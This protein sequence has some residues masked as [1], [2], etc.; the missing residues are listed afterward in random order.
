M[1]LGQQT[2]NGVVTKDGRGE[3]VLG[4]AIMLKGANSKD[5]VDRVKTTIPEI[6][7][8]LPPGVKIVPFYDR[9]DLIQAC[10]TTVS[11]S[12]AEGVILIVLILFLIL[13]DIRAALIVALLLPLTA[14]AVFIMMGWQGLTANLMSLGGLA[15]ALGMIVDGAI[16][17]TENIARHMR[18]KAN[19]GQSRLEIAYEAAKEVV[20]P[21]A[22]SF[23]IIVIVFMPLFSLGS[24]EGKWFKPLALTMIF[25][26]IGSLAVTLTVI[27]AL[28]AMLVKRKP[29]SE[30]GNPLIRGILW[31]YM[32]VLS[33]ALKRRWLA[34]GIAVA[35][36]VAA[37]AVVPRIGTEFLPPLDEGAL[38]IN[39]VRLPTASVEGSA[40]QC[41]EIEKRLLANFPEVTSVISKTGRAEISEDPMG[42]EQS[43]VLIMLKPKA[44]WTKGLTK[45]Q[46]GPR[47]QSRT[48]SHSGHPPSV[49]AA[50]RAAGQ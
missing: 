36:M 47:Y 37:L 17:I 43:D 5:V 42:P 34:L 4:M 12:I 10:I 45:E 28:A 20:R 8:S 41:T 16:V 22:F 26:L 32:P 14:A 21:V 30:H 48:G 18:E 50:H 29:E 38:A 15:I 39:I 24:T 9:T 31:G 25:A 35:M 13:W 7:K 23:V 33:L 27:P 46:A 19:S 1:K 49:F 3:A 44:Q 40:V 11:K 2:R 6:Q